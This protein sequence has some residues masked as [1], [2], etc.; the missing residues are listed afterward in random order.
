MNSFVPILYGERDFDAFDNVDD[1]VESVSYGS[2]KI[3]Q[4]RGSNPCRGAKSQRIDIHW[5]PKSQQALSPLISGS[6]PTWACASARERFL[7]SE[8]IEDGTST[9]AR[10][11]AEALRGP[12]RPF[13]QPF[14][15]GTTREPE[16]S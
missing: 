3:C 5:L 11:R 12:E 13:R 1:F 15:K 9:T 10:W 4:V 7:D 8:V 14:Q 16:P 6:S 2:Y